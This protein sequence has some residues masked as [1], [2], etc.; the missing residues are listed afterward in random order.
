[1]TRALVRTFERRFD[2]PK[3]LVRRLRLDRLIG[4]H[5]YIVAGFELDLAASVADDAFPIT[6]EVVHH[7]LGIAQVVNVKAQIASG[8]KLD[9]ITR[10]RFAI[11]IHRVTGRGVDERVDIA[12]LHI[13]SRVDGHS[14]ANIAHFDVSP[15]VDFHRAAV[16]NAHN[17]VTADLHFYRIVRF[18]LL[19]AFEQIRAQVEE[20]AVANLSA[21]ADVTGW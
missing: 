5:D 17:G 10:E 8:G 13:T 19:F 2:M 7:D 3:Y 6:A 21:G 1:M 11:Q 15:G 18:I 20:H 14:A 9:V 4:H 12:E 16:R